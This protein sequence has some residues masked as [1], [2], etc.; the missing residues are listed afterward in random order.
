MAV[1][2]GKYRSFKK[3]LVTLY[4]GGVAIGTAFAL[5]LLLENLYVTACACAVFG[6][7]MI[8]VLPISYDFGC[9]LTYPVGEA[10]TG[11]L[12]N[13]GGQVWGIVQILITNFLLPWPLLANIVAPVFLTVG[14]VFSLLVKQDLRRVANDADE[15]TVPLET[16]QKFI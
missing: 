6:F 9:E 15:K 2:V 3:G 7:L 12:L 11:G 4:I 8:P 10:M 1:I 14:L 13:A 5:S 16:S